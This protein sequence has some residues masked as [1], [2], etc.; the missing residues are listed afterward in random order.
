MTK[1]ISD[2]SSVDVKISKEKEDFVAKSKPKIKKKQHAAKNLEDRNTVLIKK[3]KAK[4]ED[5]KVRAKQVVE[6]MKES[7]NKDLNRP[8]ELYKLEK[9][10]NMDEITRQVLNTDLQEYCIENGVLN[11]I[12]IWLEPMP[13]KSLP[14]IAVKKKMLDLLFNMRYITKNNLLDSQVGKIVHF[15]ARNAKEG[16]EVR[17]MAKNL[18]TKWKGMILHEEQEE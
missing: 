15:Y 14:N 18:M 3:N 11:Q 9:L 6:L 12:R 17:R 7:Y 2:S 5:I 16:I 10:D 4:K 1:I 8:K 13:D